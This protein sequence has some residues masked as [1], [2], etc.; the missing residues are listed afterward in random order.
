VAA[1]VVP[2]SATNLLINSGF[3]EGDTG[4]IGNGYPGWNVWGNS[5]WHHDDAGKVIDTKAIKFWW[6]D[7]G[8]WQDVSVVAGQEYEFSVK[9][10]NASGD[11]LVGWN[12]NLTAQ[13]F[14]AQGTDSA[15][16]LL[17]VVVDKFYSASDPKDQWVLLSGKVTAPAGAATGRIQLNIADWQSGVGGSLNFDEASISATPEPAALLL[18][19]LGAIVFVRRR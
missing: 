9:A 5:G 1:L 8:T 11:P 19:G 4:A 12:G 10:F 6:D 18:A 13:F 3:E 7:S 15:N 17:D 14:N 16:R 2:A